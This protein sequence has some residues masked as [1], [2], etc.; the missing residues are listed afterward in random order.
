MPSWVPAARA[1]L[2]MDLPTQPRLLPG[3]ISLGAPPPS[4]APSQMLPGPSPSCSFARLHGLFPLPPN[5]NFFW[6]LVHLLPLTPTAPSSSLQPGIAQ[7]FNPSLTRPTQARPSQVPGRQLGRFGAPCSCALN[8][9]SV[10]QDGG[11]AGLPAGVDHRFHRA[12]QE[13][14]EREGSTAA[15]PPRQLPWAPR[16]RPTLASRSRGQLSAPTCAPCCRTTSPRWILQ[17]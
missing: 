1:K 2:P 13:G 4:T 15:A 5:A 3:A 14:G 6:A 7:P 10:R 8:H 16:R 11:E 17:R 9:F 12:V